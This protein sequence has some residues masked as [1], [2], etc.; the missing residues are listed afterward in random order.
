MQEYSW[1][2]TREYPLEL[3]REPGLS[4]ST[5]D[6]RMYRTADFCLWKCVP[7]PDRI[8][9]ICF[10]IYY[11]LFG[12]HVSWKKMGKWSL[13]GSQD[14]HQKTFGQYNFLLLIILLNFAFWMTVFNLLYQARVSFVFEWLCHVNCLHCSIAWN[15]QS[16]GPISWNLRKLFGPTKPFLDD[17]YLKNRELCKPETPCMKRTSPGISNFISNTFSVQRSWETIGK[18]LI[19]I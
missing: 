19:C 11:F 2:F 13:L 12:L 8:L 10:V 6:T 7:E 3:R 5:V 15:S 9:C 16:Q 1:W 18:S 17:L 4:E 14:I